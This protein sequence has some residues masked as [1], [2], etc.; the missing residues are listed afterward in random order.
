[1]AKSEKEEDTLTYDQ[2]DIQEMNE[3]YA[4]MS[5]S[6]K[7]A[8]YKAVKSVL[9]GESEESEEDSK[10][11]KS[12]ESSEEVVEA[13]E[14][15]SDDSVLAKHEELVKENEELKKSVSKLV[16]LLTDKVKGGSAAPKQ[17]AI[18]EIQYMKKSEEETVETSEI[19]TDIS[20]L[21]KA[22]VTSRL[23]DK[24]RTEELKK[25]DRDRINAYVFNE[26]GIDKI[27]DL[28]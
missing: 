7:E 21:S 16:T 19:E 13:K 27:K 14:D 3:L 15:E 18:T 5:K 8:H 24:A 9:F 10:I 2:E 28:L 11:A 12:E 25:S 20:K 4:S 22:E 17:K 26:N 23:R 1:M 6:E